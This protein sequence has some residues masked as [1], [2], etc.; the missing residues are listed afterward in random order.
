MLEYD[1]VVIG[2]GNGGLSAALTLAMQKKKVL[3]LEKGSVPGGFATSFIRGRFEFEASLHELCDYGTREKNG[4]LYKLFKQFGV[5][6][7]LDFVTVPE[8]FKVISL[9]TGEQYAMPFGREAFISKMESYVPGSRPSMTVFFDLADETSEAMAYLTKMKGRPDSKVL[10]SKYPNFMRVAPYPVKKV[11]NAIKMPQKAQRILNVY[12]SYL[13]APES[14][15]SFT[16]YALMVN[17]Y[18]NLG[19]QIPTKRSHGISLA[20]AEEI[21]R[22]G[23]EIWYD[24][25]VREILVKD[26]K[27]A[28]V[29]L[30]DGLEVK[31]SHVVS[32]ASPHTVY[33]KM[34]RSED[35]PAEEIKLA[36]ARKLA[37]R[38]LS[39][40][41]GLNR[42]AKELGLD[43]YSYFIYQSLDSDKEFENMKKPYCGSQVT[44][45]LNNGLPGC[46]PEGT[47]ILYFTSLAFSDCYSKEIDGTDYFDVKDRLADVFIDAFE[48]ATGV[49][50]RPYIEEI[51]VGTP[52][53]YAHYTDSPQGTIY[54][55]LA[56]GLDNLMPRLMTM[57]DEKR[58]PGLRFAGGH[59]MRVSGYNSSY[60]S[61]NLAANL[62]LSDMKEAS[63]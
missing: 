51:E 17:L 1:A 19:A 11:L 60:L 33:G 24:S 23:G 46:S 62:T 21:T 63:R 37:G 28:G 45:C 55:Y 35:V 10:R 36:N 8:A 25:E 14:Q 3:V 41:L 7:K 2:A 48:K 18:V 29:R 43:S 47:T 54:G 15:L 39:M 34:V 9:E 52:L 31:T 38:G 32:N 13:G 56:S 22:N 59:A 12:W 61:G 40:F 20:L 6:D 44:V 57:Y 30:A 42:S 49:S 50:I 4:N 58:L 53:T 27:V 5:A 26:G 16:H